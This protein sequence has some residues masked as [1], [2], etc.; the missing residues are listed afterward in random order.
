MSRFKPYSAYK[1]SGVT[2]LGKVPEHWEI[3]RLARDFEER[4]IRVSD[5]D[6]PALSVSKQGVVP[7]MESVA[8]TDDGDNRRLVCKGDIAINSRSDRKGS[9]G[10]VDRDG[11]VSLIITVLR[12][13]TRVSRP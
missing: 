10:L 5:K 12:P 4:R 8:K 2:W 13:S 6:Y 9:S 1:D 11:S 3:N 7:Q